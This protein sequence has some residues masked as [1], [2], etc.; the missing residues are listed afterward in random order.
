MITPRST[1]K[2]NLFAQASR[3]RKIDVVGD[4][5]QVIARHIGFTALAAL[6]KGK[7]REIKGKCPIRK[8]KGHYRLAAHR[9]LN[10]A[11]CAH[12]WHHREYKVA[13]HRI[14]SR[15]ARHAGLYLGLRKGKASRETALE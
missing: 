9:T 15:V 11:L 14:A 5:F 6:T 8:G 7:G 12:G 3:Q 4:P 2:F 13:V 10:R 1:P